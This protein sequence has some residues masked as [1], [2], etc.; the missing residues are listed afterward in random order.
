MPNAPWRGGVDPDVTA[1]DER[2]RRGR[3]VASTARS[4]ARGQYRRRRAYRLL[5]SSVHGP[6]GNR[7]HF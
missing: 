6:K 3:L 7:H 1:D 2:R 4:G 5:A